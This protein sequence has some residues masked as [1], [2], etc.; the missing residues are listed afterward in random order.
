MYKEKGFYYDKYK[1]INIKSGDIYVLNY[2]S[3]EGVSNEGVSNETIIE[4]IM[5]LLFRDKFGECKQMTNKEFLESFKD[6]TLKMLIN[7]K[8]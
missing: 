7:K 2:V 5:L 3:N 4:D 1:L 6:V 8:E